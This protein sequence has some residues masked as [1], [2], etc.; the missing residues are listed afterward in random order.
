MK[1]IK[2]TLALAI[3]TVSLAQNPPAKDESPHTRGF[4]TVNGVKLHYLDWGGSGEVILFITGMGNT[5]HTFDWIAP[6]FTDK[7]RVLAL[8]RRGY[9][10]S[11]MPESGYDVDTLTEDVRQFLDHMKIKRVI[12]IGHSA[13]GDELTNF[14]SRYPKRTL[15]LVYLDAAYDRREASKFE[16]LDPLKPPDPEDKGS[17]RERIDRMLIA[18]M[19]KY[20]PTYKKIKSPVLNYYAIWEK[21]WALRADTPADKQKAAA[22]FIETVVRP[23]QRRNIER[24][25]REVPRA[26]VIELSGTHHYFYRDPAKRDEVVKTIREFLEG[27]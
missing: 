9:G 10:E 21:H 24:F 2:L 7:F 27:R 4:A 18:G 16:D 25:K 19:S 11:D 13:G 6:K 8:T 3:A 5:A 1:L 14:A 20:D 12:L 15:K 26:R 23:Y 17:L 22:E